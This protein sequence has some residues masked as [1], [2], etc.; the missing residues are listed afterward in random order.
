MRIQQRSDFYYIEII[1][2]VALGTGHLT[3]LRFLGK[4][5]FSEILFLFI[6]CFFLKKYLNKVFSFKRDWE[7]ISRAYILVSIFIVAPFATLVVNFT[8]LSF[9]SSPVHMISFSMSVFIAFSLIQA[10]DQ[11][12][13]MENT[14]FWFFI[15]FS[16]CSIITLY[17]HPIE[18]VRFDGYRYTGGAKN[19]NQI[20]YYAQSLMLL[21]VVFFRRMA[22]IFIPILIF[23]TLKTESDAFMLSIVAACVFYIFLK[24]FYIKRYS[25]PS[26]VFI[27]IIPVLFIA[28]CILYNYQDEIV[29][30]WNNA[31]GVARGGLYLNAI[32]VIKSSPLF[33]FG[34]G[35]FSGKTVP[36][37]GTEAHSNILDL[38]IQFGVLFSALIYYILFK[39]ISISIKKGELII[40]SFM[41]AYI[42]TG[43]F[44]YTARHF[45]FW[46][47]FSI[48][49]Y[50][51]FYQ[52][53]GFLNEKR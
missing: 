31:G 22:L 6:M 43:F 45:M 26:N 40:A 20:V 36:F 19:P 13:R 53:K 21:L 25:I 7:S 42:M 35:T 50:Y 46:I 23:L 37:E 9:S 3:L 29:T 39:A 11:G 49:Y 33:G 15:T 28:F 44:H 52:S 24:L 48:F 12:F 47:E 51:V 2:G 32:E 38:A 27:Y 34:F 10:R 18:N 8:S 4:V 17:I 30:I 14:T 16:I 5:G 1:L 41:L